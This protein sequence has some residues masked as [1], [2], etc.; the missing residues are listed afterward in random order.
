MYIIKHKYCAIG[1][2]NGRQRHGYFAGFC[3]PDV[4]DYSIR[5][6]AVKFKTREEAKAFL[7]ENLSKYTHREY[8]VIVKA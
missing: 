7:I 3:Y 2:V 8:L 6:D 5:E 4:P 1:L